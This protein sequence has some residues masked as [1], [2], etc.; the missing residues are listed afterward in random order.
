[1]NS[2]QRISI[3]IERGQIFQVNCPH[4]VFVEYISEGNVELYATPEFK[5]FLKANS[6]EVASETFFREADTTLDKYPSKPYYTYH[7]PVFKRVGNFVYF[8][9]GQGLIRSV[10]LSNP[11]A[12]FVTCVKDVRSFDVDINGIVCVDG[13]KRKIQHFSS[14]TNKGN[15]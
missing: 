11:S 4:V 7:G 13:S 12:G 14:Q 2:N 10:D 5:V 9:S 8:L 1:M 3:V 15:F 6:T